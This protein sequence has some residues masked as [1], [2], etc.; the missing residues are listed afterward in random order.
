MKSQKTKTPFKRLLVPFS[1]AR[2]IIFSDTAVLVAS[3]V[4]IKASGKVDILK[5]SLDIRLE[6][7]L[8]KIP[9]A[10]KQEAELLVPVHI[11][12][13]FSDPEFKPLLNSN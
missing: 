10:K 7:E 6:P 12:G 8:A 4:R 11:S 9:K 1:I 13:R 2:G 3:Q 5:E